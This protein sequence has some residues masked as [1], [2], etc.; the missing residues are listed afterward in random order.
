MTPA[1]IR[2]SRIRARLRSISLL[3]SLKTVSG[4]IK[5]AKNRMI[6]RTSMGML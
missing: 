3:E 6:E 2:E 5:L 4:D 1:H